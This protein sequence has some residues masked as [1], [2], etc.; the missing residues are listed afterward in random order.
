MRKQIMEA[1]FLPVQ[2][3]LRKQESLVVIGLPLPKEKGSVNSFLRFLV[4]LSLARN[5]ESSLP[6]MNAE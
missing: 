4:S 6:A 3:G 2:A 5:D 1:S